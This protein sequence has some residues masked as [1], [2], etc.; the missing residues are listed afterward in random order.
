MKCPKCGGSIMWDYTYESF[1]DKEVHLEYCWGH[2]DKCHQDYNWV[3]EYI[4]TKQ[5]DLE[6]VSGC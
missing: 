2:C 6:E 5:F 3:E 1:T 4:Y